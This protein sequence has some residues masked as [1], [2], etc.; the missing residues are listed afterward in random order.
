[1]IT[2]IAAIAENGAIGLDNKLLFWLPDDM[3][4]FR[5]LTTGHTVIM[6]RRTWESLPKGALPN[7]RNIVL[8]RQQGFCA[9]GAEVLASLDAALAEFS[10]EEEVFIIGGAS[11]YA[12][13]LPYAHR[14][15]LTRVHNIPAAAD[16]FFP[17][18]SE[19]EWYITSKE[20][21]AADERH[22]Y[23]FDFVDLMRHPLMQFRYCPRCGSQ[24]F[25]N[26]NAKSRH[27]QDCNFTYYFNPSAATVAVIEREGPK[28]VEWLC[29]R[30]A[31]EPARGTLDLPGGFSDS[32]E[33]SERGVCRE[34]YEETGLKVMSTE[35]L[36]SIPNIY[37][38]SGFPVH[39]IDF[40]YRCHVDNTVE[41]NPADDAAEILWIRPADIRPADFG[42]HSIRQGVIR[43]LRQCRN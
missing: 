32:F 19:E 2:L 27:C 33:T 12:E 40:F 30:R 7:R 10:H 38:Y 26:N 15:C 22:A 5:Q 37:I 35:F 39:T 25:V 6:G 43:L 34:V 31:K 21:H 4:R 17:E 8:S 24:R 42:L 13:A 41:A 23:A 3:R 29:V 16:A 20:A 9:P 18:Y 11:I 36:F 28:G 1:M 14:L